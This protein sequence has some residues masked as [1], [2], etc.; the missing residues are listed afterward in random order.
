MIIH[1][2]NHGE[3]R[4]KI[5]HFLHTKLSSLAKLVVSASS[6]PHIPKTYCLKST[7][8]LAPTMDISS[9]AEESPNTHD[10]AKRNIFWTGKKLR[11]VRS[12]EFSFAFRE[13]KLKLRL[14]LTACPS[15][16]V[17]T[18]PIGS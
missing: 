13:T 14:T 12:T 16:E 9:V 17:E 3:S 2:L 15:E 6:V 5:L 4:K 8:T 10:M 7:Q 18:H 11:W 1:K